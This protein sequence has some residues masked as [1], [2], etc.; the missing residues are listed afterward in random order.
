[1]RTIDCPDCGHGFVNRKSRR[2]PRCG[3]WLIYDG[4]TF[5]NQPG[6]KVY[7]FGGPHRRGRTRWIDVTEKVA[8]A[9]G[10]DEHE[11][12][13]VWVSPRRR[14]GEPCI[15]GHRLPT[16]Q[17]A[18]LVWDGGMGAIRQGWPYLRDDQILVAC[19]YEV[20]H[21]DRSRWRR[22]FS[23]WPTE[24]R[25]AEWLARPAVTWKT[26]DLTAAR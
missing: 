22:R 21:G 1:M 24:Y 12:A 25:E 13:A 15:F 10:V 14:S 20:T 7:L 3:A 2:C 23:D 6:E 16:A 8:N 18:S 5:I 9:G 11:E 19:W 17:V 26:P 4:E